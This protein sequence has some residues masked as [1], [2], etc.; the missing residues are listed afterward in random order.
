MSHPAP[1][2]HIQPPHTISSLMVTIDQSLSSI[3]KISS[4]SALELVARM[5]DTLVWGEEGKVVSVRGSEVY[6]AERTPS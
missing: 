5:G 2:L 4:S 6:T 1:S 3:S